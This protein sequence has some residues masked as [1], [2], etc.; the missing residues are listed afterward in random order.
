MTS[1]TL[2]LL[3][4]TLK[5]DESLRLLP[6]DDKTGAT[7]K[8]GD[9]IQGV[10]TIGYGRALG[11]AGIN[12]LEAEDML[13]GDIAAHVHDLLA[14]FPIVAS[15]DPVRQIVLASMCF[16]IGITKLV[17]FSKMWDAIHARNFDQAAAEMILSRWADQVGARAT[18]LAEMMHSGEY[19][20]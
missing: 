17:K 15:L 7:L 18:R 20:G 4:T 1:E 19:K 9:T 16:N 5:R 11:I 13:D 10:I 3:K 14:A 2:A 8:A 12:Q 6:Y